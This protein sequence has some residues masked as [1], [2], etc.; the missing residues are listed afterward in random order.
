MVLKW[1]HN[2]IKLQH[3]E[4]FNWTT[5]SVWN[6]AKTRVAC[7]TSLLL[8]DGVL[9]VPAYGTYTQSPFL[10]ASLMRSH[11]MAFAARMSGGHVAL[12]P[13]RLTTP[14]PTTG[15]VAVAAPHYANYVSLMRRR[16]GAATMFAAPDCVKLASGTSEGLLLY[17]AIILT[18]WGCPHLPHSIILG[19]S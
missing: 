11:A 10:P 9:T 5:V 17:L 16:Q 14:V 2:I 4:N 6:L 12:H 13:Q 1:L 19:N 3:G 7:E 15:G 8:T 18:M